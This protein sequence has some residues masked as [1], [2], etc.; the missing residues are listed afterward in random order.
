MTSLKEKLKIEKNYD[1]LTCSSYQQ[2][3]QLAN[4]PIDLSQPNQ[5][6]PER[7]AKYAIEACGFKLLYSTERV[8]DEVLEALERL[9][10]EREVIKKMEQMQN[11]EEVNFIQNTPSEHRAALHT[12]TRDFFQHP[13]SAV[14]AKEAA[15]LARQETDNLHSFIAKID[16]DKDFD[17]MIVIGIGGSYLGPLANYKALQFIKHP[18]RRV[19]FVSNIDPDALSLVLRQVDLKRTL[20]LIISKSGTTLETVT[21]EDFIREKFR[22]EGLKSDQHLI[23]VTCPH[24]PLD[25]PKKYLKVFYMWDWVG[26]RFSTT[27]MA[28]LVVLAFAFGWEVTWQFLKGA[29]AMD[30]VALNPSVKNNL[31][32]FYALLSIW[33][34]NFLRYSTWALIP[35][36]QALSRYPAHIQQVAME[37]NGKSVDQQGRIVTFETSP[38]V[39]GEPGTDAQHSFFQLLHQG[40]VIV[41][42]SLVG[43]KKSQ[44][45][46]DVNVQGTT[47]QEK[48]LANLFAQA[49]ALATGQQSD[50]PNQRFTGN[51]PVNIL[52]GHQ[53]TPFALGALLAF[54]EH[55]VVFQGFIWG[56]NPFD[57]EGVQLGKKLASTIINQFASRRENKEETEYP[58]GEAFLKHLD[59]LR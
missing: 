5:L 26:G 12:A 27:S 37:S 36:S 56:I 51:R 47:S 3:S 59:S 30:K 10:Q 46:K 17:E 55:A 16:V 42:L 31:P 18:N 24:T 11:G 14:K 28:G 20:V 53:L 49:L 57:Q 52:L 19:H 58:L 25:Q 7:I 4:N 29:N 45:G 40:T 43:F 9:A 21:N 13:H 33:N 50:N 44:C 54:Y 48:L 41:P 15:S 2:L 38:V 6:T 23:C 34:H 35:Y 22:E 1:F 8:T 39:W 32:L